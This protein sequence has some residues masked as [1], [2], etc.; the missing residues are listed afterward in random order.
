MAFMVSGTLEG[1]IVR[2]KKNSRID[3]YGKNKL[4]VQGSI[5]AKV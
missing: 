5:V 2:I 1:K 4:D 3:K